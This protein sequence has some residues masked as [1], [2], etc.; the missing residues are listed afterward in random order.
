MTKKLSSQPSCSADR[1]RA[2]RG[3]DRVQHLE[4]RVLDRD[5]VDGVLGDVAVVGDDRRPSPRPRTAPGRPTAPDGRCGCH[6][7]YIELHVIGR[8]RPTMSAPVTT[9]CTPSSASAAE[10]SI[11]VDA[12]RARTALRT[13]ATCSMFGH[14]RCRRRSVRGRSGTADPRCASRARRRTSAGRCRRRQTS[15][16]SA[17]QLGGVQHRVD[18][19]HVA[20]AAAD[21]ALQ[22][23]ADLLVAWAPGCARSSAFAVSTMPGVQKPHWRPC[24]SQN[25]CCTGCSVPASRPS[26]L[27]RLDLARRRPAPRTAG[28]SAPAR[29]RAAPC[30]RRRRPARSRRA[31]RSGRGPRGGSRTAACAARPRRVRLAV[32][33]AA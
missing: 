14:A 13:N 21:V 29:R 25:A 18:D 27:D 31:C 6:D 1:A 19:E 26:A 15:T 8:A 22:R 17:H 28:T 30:R 3:A 2:D 11:A 9:A 16:A 12:W 33:R 24:F 32:D 10:V 5:Q 4:R 20:R 23:D 7:G